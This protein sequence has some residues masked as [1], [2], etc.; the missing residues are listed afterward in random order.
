[1]CMCVRVQ[2]DDLCVRVMYV[3]VLH[4]LDG[5]GASIPEKL[6]FSLYKYSYM[7]IY[8]LTHN[9]YRWNTKMRPGP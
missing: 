8:I 1:M 4:M 6:P 9:V 3:L 7:N 5:T 2:N